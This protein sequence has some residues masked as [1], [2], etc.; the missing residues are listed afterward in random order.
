MTQVD[1][2]LLIDVRQPEEYAEAN[3]GGLLIPLS[4][5]ETQPQ[6]VPMDRPVVVHCQSGGRSRQAVEWLIAHGHQNVV[7]LR[8]GLNAFNTLH[9]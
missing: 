9:G 4:E 5:L 2:P 7:N 8:G 3:L 6:L 1:A